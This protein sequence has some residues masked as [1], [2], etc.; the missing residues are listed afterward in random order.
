MSYMIKSLRQAN[1]QKTVDQIG[2]LFNS[3]QFKGKV[4]HKE[5]RAMLNSKSWR[6][7][8]GGKGNLVSAWKEFCDPE[9]G[10]VRK[11]AKNWNYIH[12]RTGNELKEKKYE[13][14]KDYDKNLSKILKMRGEDKVKNL[15]G[16]FTRG[17][18]EISI[19][20]K[21]LSVKGIGTRDQHLIRLHLTK[22]TGFRKKNVTFESINEE[23]QNSQGEQTDFKKGDMVKDI[24]PDCPHVGSEGEVTKVGSGTI[25][26]KVTNNGKNYQEGDELEKTVDQMV[27]LKE[28]VN[29]G[30]WSKIMT[31]VRKGSKAGPWSIVVYKNK[32]VIHQ[33]PVKILQQIPAHYEDVKKKYPKAKIGIEDKYGERVYTESVNELKQSISGNKMFMKRTILPITKKAGIKKVNIKELPAQYDDD[34]DKIEIT[35]DVDKET[36]DNF[37]DLLKK[38]AGKK[39]TKKRKNF[40][41]TVQKEA[42]ETAID[43]ARRV[44]KNK[45]HEKGL[46][47]TTANFI[48]KIYD[49]YK[50]HPNLQK[51]MDKMPLPK[52]V[53]LVYKV[54]K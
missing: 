26:F 53:K 37:L 22:G 15:I 17:K 45:Q 30:K 3:D 33:R 25:T 35:F 14:I 6:R 32:K 9:M 13:K 23:L 44:V 31:S 34:K 4:P 43:I 11:G 40:N 5:I 24:N 12:S 27:K 36:N 50:D 46:D 19:D 8:A 47:L 10:F 38:K 16:F 51:Q 28:S 52:M 42:K 20:G 1:V 18:G 39:G 54:M 7:F 2:E 21:N 48:V 29:E 41:L 49:A